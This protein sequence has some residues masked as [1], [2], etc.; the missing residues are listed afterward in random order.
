MTFTRFLICAAIGAVL[1][2]LISVLLEHSHQ[3]QTLALIGI[4][5]NL[6]HPR[7][8]GLAKQQSVFNWK[9]IVLAA[10]GLALML[11]TKNEKAQNAGGVLFGASATALLAS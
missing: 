9:P 7:L 5:R 2:V 6:L 11:L 3:Q 1:I 4:H 8:P 10:I